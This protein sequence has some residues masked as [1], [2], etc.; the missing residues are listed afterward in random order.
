MG[1][2]SNIGGDIKKNVFPGYDWGGGTRE[3][4]EPRR[5]PSPQEVEDE[6]EAELRIARTMQSTDDKRTRASISFLKGLSSCSDSVPDVLENGE[7]MRIQGF[8]N[9]RGRRG[10]IGGAHTV[11]STQDGCDDRKQ[12]SG[13]QDRSGHFPIGVRAS[14]EKSGGST[15]S[16]NGRT[17]QPSTSDQKI[18][19]DNVPHTEKIRDAVLAERIKHRRSHDDFTAHNNYERNRIYGG[20]RRGRL[21]KLLSTG[22]GVGEDEG[23][24]GGRW[25]SVEVIEDAAEMLLATAKRHRPHRASGDP[26]VGTPPRS[27]PKDSANYNLPLYVPTTKKLSLQQVEKMVKEEHREEVRN[28]LS[29]EEHYRVLMRGTHVRQRRVFRNVAPQDDVTKIVEAGIMSIADVNIKSAAFVKM[30]T[31]NENRKSR[32][33]LLLETRCLNRAIHRDKQKWMPKMNLP[34]HR[35]ILQGAQ[36]AECMESI[37]FRSFFYQIELHPDV[38]KYFR[39]WVN[40]VLYELNVLPM[41]ACFC[42]GVAQYIAEGAL[43]MMRNED[44]VD[45]FAYVDNLYFFMKKRA[46]ERRIPYDEIPE[47]GTHEKGTR[48]EILGRV[49]DL[50]D[51]TID[52]TARMKTKFDLSEEEMSQRSWNVKGFFALWGRVLFVAGVLHRPLSNFYSH[53]RCL[54]NVCRRFVGGEIELEHEVESVSKGYKGKMRELLRE[55]KLWGPSNIPREF[56]NEDCF[57]YTDASKFGGAYV[58]QYDGKW[59]IRMWRN[60]FVGNDVVH[61]NI[62]EALAGAK[63]VE[64]AAKCMQG[65]FSRLSVF[66]SPQITWYTDSQ[67]VFHAAN[68]GHSKNEL[69]NKCLVRIQE[70][71]AFVCVEWI[72]SAENIADG[73]SR[74]VE[75]TIKIRKHVK[76]GKVFPLWYGTAWQ[77]GKR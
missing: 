64:R 7:R 1:P 36:K 47:I 20:I 28:W 32:R 56:D 9:E 50:G 44:D 6:V 39:L 63:G 42:P 15:S 76:K 66:Q 41:G 73:P 27:H 25:K 30:K 10:E 54:S 46:M 45:A 58:L 5:D 69:I 8:V 74:G 14:E 34:S 21:K 22:Y 72:A 59:E 77:G 65:V 53:L 43:E 49:V 29:S 3:K 61:I 16:E 38:R 12:G 52:I 67:V 33:R 13:D 70:A 37:D 75:E 4:Q 60:P 23:Y 71:D 48:L 17:K 18:D 62:A 31:L 68:K 55:A 51:K 24:S 35:R 57:V 2:E 11:V 40:G 26:Y 19:N